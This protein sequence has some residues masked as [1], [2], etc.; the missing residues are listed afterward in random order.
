MALTNPQGKLTLV[1]SA[2]RFTFPVTGTTLSTTGTG[3]GLVT[4]GL[5]SWWRMEENTNTSNGILDHAY[6]DLGYGANP[7]YHGTKFGTATTEAGPTNGGNALIFSGD[8]YIDITGDSGL[9]FSTQYTYSFWVRNPVFNAGDQF[10]FATGSD[11]SGTSRVY[12][13][14]TDGG[15]AIFWSHNNT[16]NLSIPDSAFTASNWNNFVVTWSSANTRLRIYLNGSQYTFNN[17]ASATND[18]DSG[19]AVI[20][21]YLNFA[22]KF[23]GSLDEFLVY[24]RELSAAE[25]LSN[26]N[27]YQ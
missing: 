15:N 4:S 19:H 5:V 24:N 18:Q 11:N 1:E 6:S 20:G 10:V 21:A 22:N 26:Y 3:T 23:S 13:Q 27:Y 25:V 16:N 2:T 14:V 8:D 12:F 17:S 7:G 9:I